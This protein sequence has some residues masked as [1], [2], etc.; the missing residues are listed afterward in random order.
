[1]T[2]AINHM[3]ILGYCDRTAWITLIPTGRG[4]EYISLMSRRISSQ[5]NTVE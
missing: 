5:L 4:G 2:G 1:M 3:E